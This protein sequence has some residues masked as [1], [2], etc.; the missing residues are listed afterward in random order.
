MRTP[1]SRRPGVTPSSSSAAARGSSCASTDPRTRSRDTAP[2][3]VS[4]DEVPEQLA[5]FTESAS[6]RSGS[7][8]GCPSSCRSRCRRWNRCGV[9]R[10]PRSRRSSAVRTATTPSASS[11]CARSS[12]AAATACGALD[13][14]DAVHRL[15][16]TIDLRTPQV[17]DLERVRAWFPRVTD[18]ELQRIARLRRLVLRVAARAP[19]RGARRRAD[20]G[21]VLLR[22]RRRPH[23]RLPR[24]APP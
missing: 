13:V 8:R 20:R 14:G 2:T 9:C 24:R 21:A 5:L 3:D 22:A 1:S 16:E 7:R 19:R 12:R 11:A 23:P 6:L 18:E 10:S 4:T 15:L 17:V